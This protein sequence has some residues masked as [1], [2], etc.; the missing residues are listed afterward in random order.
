MGESELKEISEHCVE[1]V[2][3]L[4]RHVIIFSDCAR[5]ATNK[6]SRKYIQVCC[7]AVYEYSFSDIS[8]FWSQNPQAFPH[9]I[10][11]IADDTVKKTPA[12]ERAVGYISDEAIQILVSQLIL[13][14]VGP[15][16]QSTFSTHRAA[17]NI[18]PHGY[19]TEMGTGDWET[20]R[21]NKRI[22]ENLPGRS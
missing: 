8:V 17:I 3:T 21:P 5:S 20:P 22:I 13:P 18:R 2:W 10:W 14:K 9:S 1:A 4:R 11:W 7:F 19:R 6:Q 12:S 15:D 16:V